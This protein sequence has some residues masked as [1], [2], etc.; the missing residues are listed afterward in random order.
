MKILFSPSEA[1]ING[2]KDE[3]ISKD[4]FIFKNLYPKR[5]EVLEKYSSFIRKASLEEKIKIFGTKDSKKIEFYSKDLFSMPKMQAIKRYSG[6][7]YEYLD[8]NS[9]NEAS[10]EYIGQNLLI[11]SNLYGILAPNDKI[12]N[13]KLKQSEKIKGFAP[14]DFYLEYFSKEL[15]SL[16]EAENILDLRAGFYKKFYKIKKEYFTMKFV[17]NNKVVSHFAKAYRGL[18]L[19]N[20]S[21]IF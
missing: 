18:I 19:K 14:Q 17:K 9:L 11:F 2:G 8:F 6:V 21:K 5:L 15:D 12:P 7:S 20:Y 10:K 16:L 13:Y 4:D 3:E 1:K